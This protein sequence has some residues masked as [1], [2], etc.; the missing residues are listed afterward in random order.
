MDAAA[1]PTETSKAILESPLI[2]PRSYCFEF[3]YYM[4]GEDVGGELT[5]MAYFVLSWSKFCVAITLTVN[6]C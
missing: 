6:D 4:Y 5:N 1:A 2:E 3:Y